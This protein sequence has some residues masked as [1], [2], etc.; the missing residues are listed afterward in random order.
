MIHRQELSVF[1]NS[2]SNISQSDKKTKNKKIIKSKAMYD[3][4]KKLVSCEKNRIKAIHKLTA[5]IEQYNE[6]I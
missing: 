2:A 1:E 3:L 6:T 5:A 4:R